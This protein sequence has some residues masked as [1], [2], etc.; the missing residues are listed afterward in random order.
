MTD[1]E[2]AFGT[3]A[4][5][6]LDSGSYQLSPEVSA[7]LKAAREQ[8]IA[9]QKVSVA[10]Y[11]IAGLPGSF[12]ANYGQPLRTLAALAA[13]ALGIAGTYVWNASQAA[14]ENADTDAALLADDLP[15]EA[16]TDQGFRAWLERSRQSAD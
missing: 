11:R 5:K 10:G 16:Y 3:K 4:R 12:L 2:I 7:R 6:I 9:A 13:L 14:D 15:V 8:A 1:H